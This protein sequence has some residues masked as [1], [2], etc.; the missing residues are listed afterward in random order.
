MGHGAAGRAVPRR[1]LDTAGASRV[2]TTLQA[3]AAPTRLLILA[4]LNE[5]PMPATELP[6]GVGMEQPGLTGTPIEGA[7]GTPAATS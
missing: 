2:A 5:G 7:A 1:P 6:H 3:L 4:Q